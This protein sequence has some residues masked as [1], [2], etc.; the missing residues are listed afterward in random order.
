MND[1]E[2]YWL[3]YFNIIYLLEIYIYIF[4]YLIYTKHFVKIAS[5]FG[6]NTG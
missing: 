2:H 5:T 3:L 6:D 4:F 1:K